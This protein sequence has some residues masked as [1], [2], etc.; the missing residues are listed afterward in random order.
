MYGQIGNPGNHDPAAP[1]PACA[2]RHLYLFIQRMPS[3]PLILAGPP[4]S[5]HARRQSQCA[6]VTHHHCSSI[7]RGGRWLARPATWMAGKLCLSKSSPT[8]H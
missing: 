6:D 3:A 7:R 5:K 1:V 2:L 8:S 4:V